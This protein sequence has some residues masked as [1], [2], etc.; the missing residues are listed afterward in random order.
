M[1]STWPK[2]IIQ[3]RNVTKPLIKYAKHVPS[4][5]PDSPRVEFVDHV[6]DATHFDLLKGAEEFV[7]ICIERTKYFQLFEYVDI[8]E[9]RSQY[10]TVVIFRPSVLS[11]E[12]E[13]QLLNKRKESLEKVLFT[14]KS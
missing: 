10:E 11:L 2:Y 7:N 14:L 4:N 5:I 12:R 8:I 3:V 6:A 9:S 13:L 1:F